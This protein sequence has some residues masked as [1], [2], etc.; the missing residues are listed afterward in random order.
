MIFGA[1]I[2]KGP[3]PWQII[4]QVNGVADISISGHWDW[5]VLR[6]PEEQGKDHSLVF[7]AIFDETDGSKVVPWQKVEMHDDFTWEHTFRDVPAGGPYRIE[8]GLCPSNA[9]VDHDW[10]FRGDMIHYIGVGDLYVI[11]GQSNAVGYAKDTIY[12]P[13]EIG[14]H[15][16]RADG[17]WALATHP[18]GDSTNSIHDINTDLSNTGHSP[19]IAFAKK[20]KNARRYPIGLLPTALGGSAIWQWDTDQCGE[21]WFEM[22]DVINLAGG[23]IAGIIWYQGCTDTDTRGQADAYYESFKKFVLHTR[24]ELNAP[25][26][27]FHTFQL[28]RVMSVRPELPDWDAWW[29]KVRD[30]QRRAAADIPNVFIIPTTDIALSD[31]IH[32]KA[33]GNMLLADRLANQVLDHSFAAPTLSIA[34]T[35]HER[36]AVVLYFSNVKE[37][38]LERGEAGDKLFEIVDAWGVNKVKSI[39]FG[40]SNQ[41]TLIPERELEGHVYVS[42]IWQNNPTYLMPVDDTTSMPIVSFYRVEANLHHTKW[43]DYEAY[44][45]GFGSRE[46]WVVVPNNPRPDKR[47]VWRTEF[48]GAFDYADR[49]LL[50]S[51]YYLVFHAMHDMYGCPKSIDFMDQFWKYITKTFGLRGDCVLIGLSRGGLYATNFAARFPERVGC[52]YIDAP[53]LDIRSWPGGKGSGAGDEGCWEECKAWYNLTEETAKEFR[54]NPL[55]KVETLVEGKVPCLLVAGLADDLV[56]YNENGEIFVKKYEELGGKIKTLLKPECGHHPHSFEDPKEIVE[57]IEEV[58]G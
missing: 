10:D 38:L 31:G 47:F 39:H 45:F 43:Y 41:I 42:G 9:G 35:N 58:M 6:F 27:P 32:N 48:F 44:H 24:K 23:K 52:L 57:F 28:N 55:D 36:N 2:D 17:Q 15:M 5:N 26:L 12:D 54:D 13:P 8:T 4:Q 18:L 53:V 3:K 49:A 20:V 34:E 56:P 51:G 29:G 50:D 30:A 46:S 25:D 1:F 33:A 21:L 14:V 16:L 11:A 37:Q 22:M 19:F 7:A 40:P